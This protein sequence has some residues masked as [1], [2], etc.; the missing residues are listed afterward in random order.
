M[1]IFPS[2]SFFTLEYMSKG[3][4]HIFARD[5]H[6]MVFEVGWLSEGFKNVLYLLH[7][8]SF[9]LGKGG[10]TSKFVV[11]KLHLDFDPAL[12]FLAGRRPL[13]PW[14]EGS[15]SSRTPIRQNGLDV[16]RTV[17]VWNSQKW[18]STGRKN[19]HV[20]H[21][22]T[23]R[24]VVSPPSDEVEIGDPLCSVVMVGRLVGSGRHGAGREAV[25][26]ARVGVAA[27]GRRGKVVVAVVGMVGHPTVI[28]RGRKIP[29][30]VST[31]G[32]LHG[33]GPRRGLRQSRG[34]NG[35]GNWYQVNRR[36][37]DI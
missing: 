15:A 5:Q 25:V 10:V 12:G 36:Q 11:D 14:L 26:E 23:W 31:V 3:K 16:H 1:S 18:V 17:F 8:A 21:T 35:G 2:R 32:T 22:R 4:T 13:W 7:D 28:H 19:R 9:S 30:I 20:C 37:Q 24:V 29:S 33:K 34:L 27:A 6:Q